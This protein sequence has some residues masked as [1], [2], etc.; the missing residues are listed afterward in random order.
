MPRGGGTQDASTGELFVALKM[1]LEELRKGSWDV[2]CL[3]Q[4][5]TSKEELIS[6]LEYVSYT[7]ALQTKAEKL[8]SMSQLSRL[9][10]ETLRP[11]KRSSLS[12]T[13]S[14]TLSW[15]AKRA[16][17]RSSREDS[18]CRP[19]ARENAEKLEEMGRAQKYSC[20][21]SAAA[22]GVWMTWRPTSWNPESLRESL[23]L[24]E[25][26]LDSIVRTWSATRGRGRA[27]EG[28][29]R[30][31]AGGR[32]GEG[33]GGLLEG[34]VQRHRQGC[35]EVPSQ[36]SGQIKEHERAKLMARVTRKRNVWLTRQVRILK[37]V[38]A[39]P[40][41]GQGRDS[42]RGEG[43]CTAQNSRRSAALAGRAWRL[44]TP[45][46]RRSRLQALLETEAKEKRGPRPP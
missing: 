3:Q 28:A 21:K 11:S 22:S 45:A 1:L 25:K 15:S 12:S 17:W 18:A 38:Q 27:G 20:T 37:S 39:R 29:R 14:F 23:E 30:H 8:E 9:A 34:Q 13:S 35:G 16:S 36:G 33:Q 10:C 19:G 7:A 6:R 43:R 2:E 44:R 31:H 32:R 41:A 4:D 24:K 5:L 26:Q 40:C 42:P 46:G